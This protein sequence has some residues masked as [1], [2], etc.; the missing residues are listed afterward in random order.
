VRGEKKIHVQGEGSILIRWL[1]QLAKNN[2]GDEMC[3]AA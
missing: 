3:R 1:K 2:M